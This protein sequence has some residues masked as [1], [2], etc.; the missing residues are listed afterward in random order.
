MPDDAWTAA[1]AEII[2]REVGPLQTANRFHTWGPTIV[3]GAQPVTGPPV[4]LKASELQNVAIEAATCERAGKAGVPTPEVL[5]KGTDERLPGGRW[6]LMRRLPGRRWTDVAFDR[7]GDLA[8]L[9][10]LAACLRALHAIRLPGYGRLTE[11]GTGE[12][13]SWEEWLADGFRASAGPLIT[14]G[15]LTA[16]FHEL[17]GDVLDATAPLLAT[18]PGALI[19]G[20]LGDGE[21]YV[22][23]ET[24]KIT[25]LVDWGAAVVGDPVYEFS[26]FV[27]GGPVDDPRPE[28]YRPALLDFY[29]RPHGTDERAL[30]DLYD[31]YNAI[32]NAAWS[33]VEGYD[34]MDSL[35]AKGLGLLRDLR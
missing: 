32:D 1:A 30:A 15:H 12:R 7:Q 9:E 24:A 26:R 6:F 17:V 8:V 4:V 5:A 31:A 28:V 14:H 29:G 33:L 34:W 35:C 22:D 11:A 19:H 23:P 10:Q 25:G 3:L 20:D 21:V 13:A 2:T 27:A 18:R 16:E